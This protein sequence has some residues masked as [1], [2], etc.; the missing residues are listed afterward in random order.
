MGLYWRILPEQVSW[1]IELLTNLMEITC[2]LVDE[3]MM[4]SDRHH[5]Q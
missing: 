5:S 4:V 2:M 1:L 3:L